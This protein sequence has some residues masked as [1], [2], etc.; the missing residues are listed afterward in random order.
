MLLFLEARRQRK[1]TQDE[2]GKLVGAIIGP[3]LILLLMI[4]I[5]L[6]IWTRRRAINQNKR[7]TGTGD[8]RGDCAGDL[9]S[10]TKGEF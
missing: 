10:G 3:I 1:K 7:S 2:T 5:I 8:K 4:C 6:W 9:E